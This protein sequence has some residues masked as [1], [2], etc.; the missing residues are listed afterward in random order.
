M[1]SQVSA[2]P[3]AC[4]GRWTALHSCCSRGWFPRT[5]TQV[6]ST[7]PVASFSGLSDRGP[8][9]PSS[10]SSQALPKKPTQKI[11]QHANPLTHFNQKP[12]ELEEEW[13]VKVFPILHKQPAKSR[14]LII[15]IGCAK[16]GW[17][18]D[19]AIRYP[20]HLIIG[21]EL[22]PAAIE[23]CNYRKAVLLQ[24]H[25]HR[26]NTGFLENVL[27]LKSNANVDLDAILS[28]IHRFNQ[29][30]REASSSC[31]LSPLTLE[32]IT[33]QFP[34]PHFKLSHHKRRVVNASLLNILAKG[35]QIDSTK[36]FIQSDI[37]ELMEDMM[38]HVGGSGYFAAAE[39][40]DE[41]KTQ[42]QISPFA[43]IPTEREKA[44]QKQHSAIYRMLYVRN[45][46][47]F[48]TQ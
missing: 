17:V 22:R 13:L 35:A 15:D 19:Y 41:K 31:P 44:C 16:G 5:R 24:T 28:S 20:E 2:F 39:G 33:I 36:L 48:Q 14:K 9:V 30:Q 40:Y 12:I 43:H 26:D 1:I 3:F 25:P 42:E 21:L 18:L 27:F 11:R 38:Q 47:P 4:S 34:D 46:R 32:M 29:Q 6:R 10:S 23:L 7:L 8:V 37:K 45:S